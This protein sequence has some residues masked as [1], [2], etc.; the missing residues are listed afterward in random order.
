MIIIANSAGGGSEGLQAVY[1]SAIVS[2]LVCFIIANYFSKLLRFFP[3]VVTG[4]VIT[5][6]GLTLMP[7][8]VGWIAGL[9]PT[10]ADFADPVYIMMAVL[11]LAIIIIF[12][13]CFTGFLSHIA[14]LLGLILGTIIACFMGYVD[15]TPVAKAASLGI[16]TPFAFGL[17]T[18][19]PAACVAMTLVMLVT[20]AET[21]GDMMAITEIVEKPM[22]KNLLTRALRADGFSTMLGGVLNAFPYTA[23]AQNIG[24]ITL[25]GVRSRYVVATSAVIM[26]LLGL[27]PKLAAIV[28]C[29]PP[30]VLGGA[31]LAM[32][33][34]VAASGIRSLSKVEFHDNCNMMVIAISVG[35]AMIPVCS[36]GFYSKFPVTMQLICNSSITIGSITAM[37]LN[38]L[39][40]KPQKEE[41]FLEEN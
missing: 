2:G 13:R 21:T 29:I 18:F 12:Y 8:A 11:V 38:F 14:V 32:F 25:T 30:M 1:G 27:C 33:G 35:V 28:S 5:I 41:T 7:V 34:M 39:L 31:G 9:D 23:F 10:A 22:S 37:L 6:I 16:T 20:M 40:N 24:L 26:M 17:P 3:P 15:F 4:S 19:D 36:P